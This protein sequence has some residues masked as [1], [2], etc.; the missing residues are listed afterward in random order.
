MKSADQILTAVT[1][2]SLPTVMFGGYSLLRLRNAGRLTDFQARFFRIG[3]A[4]AGV[5][6]VATLAALATASRFG[7]SEALTWAVGGLLLVGTLALPG[8]M[9]AH[10]GF[11][12]PGAWS[13]GNTLS[14]VGAV[15]L[16]GGML[17]LAYG[18]LTAAP[19]A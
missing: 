11:G 9:F 15:L 14:A 12:K 8:G 10:M 13:W 19:P 5:L 3:H 1:L 18:V 16:A 4:H 2:I 17:T 6:L 7:L